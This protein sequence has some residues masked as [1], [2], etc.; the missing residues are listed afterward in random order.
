MSVLVL[1]SVGVALSIVASMNCDFLY[2][3]N[4]R[5]IP[6][7]GLTAPFEGV[8]KAKV[9]IFSYQIIEAINNTDLET[10]G[11]VSYDSNFANSEYEVLVAAQFC[12][13]FAPLLALLAIIT[14]L[15]DTCIC[16]FFLS[17]L[18]TSAL[19]LA[20][21]GVQAGTFSLF[22]EPDIWYVK[23]MFCWNFQSGKNLADNFLCHT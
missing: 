1:A 11:C 16:S 23:K 9:G 17:F 5:G 7:E 13:V 18:I 12:G 14:N 2:F 22:A 8:T 10:D 20:A 6:W 4:D 19:F 3:E 15:F 21:C